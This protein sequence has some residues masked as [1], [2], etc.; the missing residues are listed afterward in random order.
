MLAHLRRMGLPRLIRL[1]LALAIP[2]L[3]YEIVVLHY[4]GSF[5]NRFMWVPVL[6]LPVVMGSTVASALKKDERRSR[7]ILHPFAL[8][9]AAVGTLG[10][11]F[12]LRG[13]ARQM[14]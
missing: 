4:R 11:F 13:I 3:W 6:G 7:E 12:H 9:M 10:T 1:G 14:G 2:P 8:I 5:Q